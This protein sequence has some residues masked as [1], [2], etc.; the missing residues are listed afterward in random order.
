MYEEKKHI[1]INWVSLL[2]KCILVLAIIIVIIII[3]KSF[4]GTLFRQNISDETFR[5]N[6]NL[7][8]DS[9]TEY[10]TTNK[11][12]D[13]A[14]SQKLTLREMVDQKLLLD[15]TN[16]NKIC[17]LDDSYVQATKMADDNYALKIYLKC[18]KKEDFIVTSLLNTENICKDAINNKS[19][20]NTTTEDKSEVKEEVKNSS[21]TSSSK[22]DNKQSGS[23]TVIKNITNITIESD[24]SNCCKDCDKPTPTPEPT[25]DPKPDEPNKK[26]TYYK[27]VKYSKWT[28]EEITG[29]N[30][31]TKYVD[32]KYT[33][34][35]TRNYTKTYYATGV[36]SNNTLYDTTYT[37]DVN[38]NDLLNVK[39][40]KLIS[41]D[42]FTSYQDY[43]NFM[44]QS[45]KPYFIF[46]DTISGKVCINKVDL[47][48]QAS[49]TNNNFTY[50]INK[51]Y[52][53]NGQ[54]YVS[55]TVS[56]KNASGIDPICN[57][58]TGERI[59]FTPIKFKISYS[60]DETCTKTK[61][62][63]YYRTYTYKWSLNK[64]EEGYTYTGI[65]EERDQ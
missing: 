21:S 45:T 15:F 24:C 42:Y 63:K 29:S 57:C 28:T 8:K 43:V 47:F 7:M 55:I 36:M 12:K 22:W 33:T 32:E 51:V 27:L 17:S 2:V 38:I 11:L 35:C 41:H 1:K 40:V 6:L 59:F 30:V 3:A 62:V 18:G 31:E 4:K 20:Q 39:N 9:A 60:K 26:V 25:P 58:Y 13:D 10:F 49:L 37:K 50:K 65:S 46:G 48:K 56:Y 16:N 23:S 64:Y 61:K 5:E 53:K 19:C 54:Y 34:T 44:N 14:R 52:Q